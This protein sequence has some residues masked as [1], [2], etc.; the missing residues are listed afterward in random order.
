MSNLFLQRR[1]VERTVSGDER[2]GRQ[3]SWLGPRIALLKRQ[4]HNR[5]VLAEP[6]A[7]PRPAKAVVAAAATAALA[8][9]HFSEDFFEDMSGTFKKV[10][11]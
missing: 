9:V 1:D 10:L 11:C 2:R 5:A 6:G 7:T 8:S 4:R 3:Q